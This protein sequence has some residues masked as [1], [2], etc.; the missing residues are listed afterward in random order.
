MAASSITNTAYIYKRLYSDKQVGDLAERDHVLYKMCRKEDGFT[1]ATFHYAIRYGNP[2]GVSGTFSSSQTAVSTSK[3]VQLSTSRKKKYGYITIDGESLAAADGNKGSF[4]DLV[5]QETDGVIEEMGDALG[6]DLY[7]AGDGNRGRRASAS[8]DVITLE[9]ADDARNFKV[10]MTVV[11]DDDIAGGSLRTGSTTVDAVDED[12]GTIE[13]ASAAA[14]TSFA[15]NDYLFRLGDPATCVEGL[16][17]LVP[18]TAP[19]FG[20]DSF[21]GIDR[22]AHARLLSGSRINDT[23]TRIEENAGLAAVKISQVGKRANCGFLNPIRFWEVVR[24][25]NAKVEYSDNTGKNAA[26]G[27]ESFSLHTAAGMVKMYADPDCPTNRGYIGK[28]ESL[29]IKSLKAYPHILNDDGL[30]NLRLSSED[31]IEGRARAMGNT[32]LVEPG[33]WAVFAI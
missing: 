11:A 19:V 10:G 20:S 3:G 22:G 21:R 18:L 6:F 33:S 31:G 25:L 4:L 27:F 32:V 29:Y 17:D 23:A 28:L 7:R 12:A 5:R 24:R 2:Q 15:D 30:F 14:I 9:T 8:S 13:L 16:A 1:G 26:Y